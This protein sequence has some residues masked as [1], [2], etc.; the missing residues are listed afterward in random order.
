MEVTFK[1]WR[2]EDQLKTAEE[3]TAYIQAAAEEGTPDALPDAFADVFRSMGFKKE[4]NLCDG[5]AEYLRTVGRAA[6]AG[7]ARGRARKRRR[8]MATA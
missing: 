2:I 3:R 8:E 6:P 4:A 5:L 7:A 1:E